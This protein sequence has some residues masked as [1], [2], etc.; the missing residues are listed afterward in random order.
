MAEAGQSMA[1]EAERLSVALMEKVL[2]R[3][4]SS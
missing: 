4:I 3:R 1:L 2:E